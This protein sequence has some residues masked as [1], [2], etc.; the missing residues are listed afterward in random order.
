M[1]AITN[2]DLTTL[3]IDGRGTFDELMAASNLHLEKEFDGNRITGTKYAEVYLGVMNN[4]LSQ[5]IQ[6]QL[7]RQAADKQ[8]DLLDQQISNEALKNALIQAQINKLIAET[9]NIVQDTLNSVT[10]GDNLLSTGV[11]IIANTALVG[12]QRFKTVADTAKS[13]ADKLLTDQGILIA[14]QGV[15]EAVQKVALTT[16]QVVKVAQDTDVGIAQ[17]ANIVQDTLVKL[18]QVTKTTQDISLSQQQE[19]NLVLDGQLTVNQVADVAQKTVNAV[20]SKTV[21]D[22]QGLKIAGETTLLAQKKLTEEAQIVDR[23][24]GAAGD[25]VGTIGQQKLLYQGQIDGF[26]R[27]AEQKAVK[28]Q[29]D[30]LNVR[31]TADPDA[32]TTPT[33]MA[34]S[35][36]ND[37]L[38]RLK[39]GI[40]A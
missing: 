21:I 13:T 22:N 9:A 29:L 15:L 7:G 6:F 5:S 27:D 36:I 12:E 4:V 35:E 32:G 30:A 14:V 18:V 23:V 11:G 8:A 31:T 39:L 10:V 16:N 38:V 37:Y 33:G 28:L 20:A 1:T 34:N 17:E 19:S 24:T 2:N 25:V 26:K 3:K 40:G